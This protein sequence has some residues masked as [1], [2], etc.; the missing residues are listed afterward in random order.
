[1]SDT[2]APANEERL[3]AAIGPKAEYYL[4]HWREMDESG[5]SYS[6]NWPACLLN[7]FW[8]A[9]RKMWAAMAAMAL[10][11]VVASPFLDPT[12]RTLF[13]IVAFSMVGL[14]FVTGGFSNLLYRRQIEK[15]VAGPATLEQLRARGGVSLAAAIASFVGVTVLSALAGMIPAMLGRGG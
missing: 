8:F 14:S 2:D 7:A 15:L 13:R 9:Y 3:R 6:W 12:N 11:Y 5:K 1:M 10:T 4:R